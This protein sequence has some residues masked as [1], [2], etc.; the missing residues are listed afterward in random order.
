MGRI[1][2][3]IAFILGFFG[4]GS[5]ADLNL[6]NRAPLIKLKT[7]TGADFDLTSRKGHW[8]VLYFYPKAETPGC[9]KQACAFRDSLSEIR[10][11][12][13]E[14]FGI[15]ADNVDALKKFKESHKLNFTLLAD[16]DLEAIKAYGTKMPLVNM[17]KRWTFII[18]PDL[19][20]QWIEKEV[21]PVLDAA[22]VAEKLRELQ[23]K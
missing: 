9:T 2:I 13:A 12:D 4:S 21:D 3:M 10:K 1:M 8:T 15:S 14:L 7:D 5:A 11:L 6:G 20:I 23:S 22:R 18:G 19:Q 17:S 16:P